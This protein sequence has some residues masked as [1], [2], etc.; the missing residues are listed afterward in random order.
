MDYKIIKKISIYFS[1][2]LIVSCSNEYKKEEVKKES[3][4][5]AFIE[6]PSVIRKGEIVKGKLK[7]NLN[8]DSIKR[9]NIKERF[10]F[11]YITKDANVSN[12]EEL[13]KHKHQVF[14]EGNK[15]G[16]IG[17]KIK[18]EKSG[19]GILNCFLVDKIYIKKEKDKIDIKTKEINIT[20]DVFVED[21][22]SDG[23][24]GRG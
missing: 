9:E 1:I 17:F 18:F 22:D 4:K 14:V 5:I 23:Q 16:V 7:Y 13:K 20:K 21:I 12:I 2:F 24:E 6:F 11:L 15:K 8:L 3:N 10:I 19:K